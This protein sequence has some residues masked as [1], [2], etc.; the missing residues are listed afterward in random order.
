MPLLRVV[1]L[2]VMLNARRSF[3]TAAAG[4]DFMRTV[5]RFWLVTVASAMLAACAQERPGQPP[6]NATTDGNREGTSAV[7]LQGEPFVA[8]G[9]IA[10]A[11]AGAGNAR[12]VSGLR[13]EAH[14]GCERFVIDLAG[15][16]GSPAAGA[17]SV[18]VELIR[19][20]GVVRV[21]LRDVEQVST[22]A[23][24][25]RPDGTLI[26]AG[27]VVR[28]PEGGHMFVDLHLGQPAEAHAL[29]LQDP[30]RVVIDVRPG[31][32][33]LTAQAPAE[34][35][36]VVLEPRPGTASYPLRVSGYARTFEAN[37][38]ARIEKAGAEPVETFTT[39][40]GWVDSWG[41]Y[42]LVFDVGPTGSIVLHVG[43]YSAKDGSWEG[44]RVPLQ[45]R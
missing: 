45:I 34:P 20:L 1:L 40:T 19:R 16:D 18:D 11:G 13:W 26:R 23:T 33:P 3:T 28:S 44:V 39:S 32:A 6:A 30:A 2:A 25:T 36:V 21:S 43:E 15:V 9:A 7:C 42:S 10:V 29:L 38:V 5:P 22:D 8:D 14:D 12:E 37:V 24:D 41:Y 31:G 17:G 35:R 27:Y 4:H